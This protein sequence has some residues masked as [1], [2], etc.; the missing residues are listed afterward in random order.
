MTAQDRPSRDRSLDRRRASARRSER[1]SGSVRDLTEALAAPLRPE[2]QVVQSMADV[3]PTK[4]HRGHTTWFFETFLLEPSLTGYD[5]FDADFRYL[6]NSYY[7]AVG[8]RH[9]RNR[10]AACCR[11]R[12]SKRSARYR[13]HVDAAMEKLIDGCDAD[14]W[15]ESPRSSSSGCTTSS[16]TRSCCS[17]TS[18][19]CCRAT[20]SNP[21]TST[22]RRR[23]RRRPDAA[24][25]RRATTA[26]SSRSATIARADGFAFDN[27]VAASQG[28]PRAVPASPTGSSPPAS[29]SSSWTT[30]ATA[31]PSS[32]SPT[33][34]TPCRSTAGTRRAYWRGDEHDGW[35]AFTLNGRRPVDPDEPVV[36]VS[37]YEADAFARWA[38]ARL[39]TEFEWE[40]AVATPR[41]A[42]D[43]SGLTAP[44]PHGAPPA[45]GA[46]PAGRRPAQ[47]F[48]DVWQ[49]TASAYLPYPRFTP[50]AGAVG[51]YNGKFMS[52][53]MVLRGG[54]V[55]HPGRSRPHDL[56]E[57]L[58]ARRAVGCSRACGSRPTA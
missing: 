50:A 4:W 44:A 38:G 19:T 14:A 48:G 6:F 15:P 28:V 27:E 55:H 34:G 47:A 36:H 16:S 35:S 8:P 52:G 1:D 26:G 51:E 53:Q 39:P 33:A 22:R 23:S 5:A 12:P 37:H 54:A 18:S 40:H 42:P 32:G 41:C 21:P 58:P 56:P 45:P 13:A 31:G 24:A 25:L 30:A 3:S 49:W 57:L 17:W 11:A 7:E 29:G 20:R 2:D 10:N 9:P 43:A 46:A